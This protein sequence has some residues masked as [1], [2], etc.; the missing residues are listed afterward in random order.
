MWLACV[1]F[2]RL[3][4]FFTDR[5]VIRGSGL[6]S[7]VAADQSADLNLKRNR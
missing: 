3:L 6:I 7:H 5:A 2:G 1:V 4:E